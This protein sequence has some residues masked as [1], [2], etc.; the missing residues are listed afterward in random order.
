MCVYGSSIDPCA[1][2]KAR[3]VIFFKGRVFKKK[4][5]FWPAAQTQSWTFSHLRTRCS[6]SSCRWRLIWQGECCRT[7]SFVSSH[8][9]TSCS[10]ACSLFPFRVVSLFI[11][12]M[13]HSLRSASAVSHT[14][15]DLLL[16]RPLST[17]LYLFHSVCL[18]VCV[19]VSVCVCVCVC[20]SSLFPPGDSKSV[21]MCRRQASTRWN[22]NPPSLR[23]ASRLCVFEKLFLKNFPPARLRFI[24]QPTP[25]WLIIPLLKLGRVAAHSLPRKR[26]SIFWKEKKKECQYIRWNMCLAV[27]IAVSLRSFH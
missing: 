27:W 4:K 26:G 5:L 1:W 24:W 14:V 7:P 9:H 8:T 15:I 2:D 21:C 6:F 12:F 16:F 23:L 13:S 18:C 20:V 19:C 22:K 11:S 17:N 3:Q 10:I 25:F